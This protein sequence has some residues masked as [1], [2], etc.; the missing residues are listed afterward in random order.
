MLPP[1]TERIGQPGEDC[2]NSPNLL[3]DYVEIKTGEI[4]F[5]SLSPCMVRMFYQ[6][7]S[8]HTDFSGS[9][10]TWASKLHTFGLRGKSSMQRRVQYCCA[11]C[12]KGFTIN[13]N[14]G[15]VFSSYIRHSET[16]RSPNFEWHLLSF[17]LTFSMRSPNVDG[18]WKSMTLLKSGGG[19]FRL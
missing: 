18:S 7:L 9:N 8:S 17:S 4:N 16:Q 10:F 14:P 19:F 12:K 1:P 13:I 11:P 6:W 15:Q 2:L 3:L 5:W